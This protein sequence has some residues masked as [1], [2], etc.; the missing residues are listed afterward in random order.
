MENLNLYQQRILEG[1]NEDYHDNNNI[2]GDD[3]DE[4]GPY[5]RRQRP[6][7][8]QSGE[9][10]TTQGVLGGDESALGDESSLL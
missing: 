2:D 6:A 5:Q 10:S 9:E 8:I 4:D 7:G 3:E 1:D